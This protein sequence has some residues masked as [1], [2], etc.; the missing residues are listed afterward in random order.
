MPGYT[1]LSPCNEGP[2]PVVEVLDRQNYRLDL[3][4]SRLQNVHSVFHV[5]FLSAYQPPLPG[6]QRA[7]RPK[8]VSANGEFEFEAIVAHKYAKRSR[9]YLFRVHWTGYGPSEDTW[10]PR[11]HL[12]ANAVEQYLAIRGLTEE[13]IDQGSQN[14]RG[15]V[16]PSGQ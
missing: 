8:A 12:P 10:E 16:A 9:D 7:T 6:Q 5:S 3:A 1:K 11:A 2:F 13:T 15:R 4:H 14:R